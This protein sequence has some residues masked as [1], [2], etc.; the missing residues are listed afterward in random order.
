ME[1]D[2]K[3]V[4]EWVV[5]ATRSVGAEITSPWFYLQFGVLMVAGFALSR[6]QTW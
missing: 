6:R 3:D 1:N 2:L 4:T 5:S